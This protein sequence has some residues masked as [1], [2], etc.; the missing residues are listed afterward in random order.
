MA[1]KGKAIKELET[2]PFEL[3]LEG[4]LDNDLQ[5]SPE[6]LGIE[7]F[8]QIFQRFKKLV[9]LSLSVQDKRSILEQVNFRYE[10]GS[11]IL[12][13]DI[14]Q[15]AH[16]AIQAEVREI[17]AGHP[18]NPAGAGI[19]AILLDL[20][21]FT[22]ELG[23]SA[24]ITIG[25]EGESYLQLSEET[26]FEQLKNIF[27]S[28]ELIVY[29]KLFSVGGKH[30]NIHVATDDYGTLIIEVSEQQATELAKYLYQD[31]G[32]QISAEQNLLTYEIFSPSFQNTMPYSRDLNEEGFKRDK[33]LG[34]RIWAGIDP[35]AWVR[36]QR[37]GKL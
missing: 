32:L 22:Q 14:P 8:S 25:T 17:E 18:I 23:G 16:I 28:T 20:K 4:K 35:V 5:I 34:T 12:V 24:K 27:V 13:S 19:A 15:E 37:E 29:G 7:K 33:E 2:K 31:I 21:N 26:E 36:E 11:A 9:E 3:K 6:T 10:H 30:P 1:T